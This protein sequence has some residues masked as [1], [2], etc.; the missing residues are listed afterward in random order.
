MFV[1]LVWSFFSVKTYVIKASGAVVSNDKNYI[2]SSYSGEITRAYIH[3]G[4]YVKEGDILFSVS[5]VDLDLQEIQIQGVIDED[6]NKIQMFQ[7]LENCIK[8]GVNEFDE[9]DY[10]EKSY[11]Y[12]FET[13]I[14]QVAQK[15]LD[16]SSYAAYNYTDE[17]IEIVVENNEASIAEIYSST[18][19]GIADSVQ[20]LQN[21]INNY[22]LQL[23]SVQSGRADYPIKASTSGIVHMDTEYKEG[24]VVQSGASIGSIISENDTYTAIVYALA[25][26]MP[27]IHMGDRVDVAVSGLTQSIYGTI[28]GTVSY[29]ASEATVNSENNT[30]AFQVKIDLDSVY[31]ISNQGNQVKISN[32][33][34]VEARIKY[35]EVTYFYYMLEA[36]GVL[37][38]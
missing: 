24:M 31:L 34:A 27:L 16:L 2:M 1:F 38:R 9:N 17:Q 10:L 21:E 13:Y 33:M 12:Q 11:Y 26:D 23:A 32:G 29:I 36:L 4:D 8:N 20:Q 14:N 18:L 6:R 22:Q 30:S 19:K 28:S 35:D 5:S 15:R 3:E 7:R 25:N 37:T